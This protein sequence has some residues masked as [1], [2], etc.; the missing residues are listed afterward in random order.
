MKH[1]NIEFMK[2]VAPMFRSP[3]TPRQGNCFEEA[4]IVETSSLDGFQ[5]SYLTLFCAGSCNTARLS[6]YRI[7]ASCLIW[8]NSAS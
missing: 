4:I 5:S 6:L 2:H 3:L 7:L 8:L 1:C